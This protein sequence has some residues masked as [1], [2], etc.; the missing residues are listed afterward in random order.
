MLA[1]LARYWKGIIAGAGAVAIVVQAAITDGKITDDEKWAI[2][3][4]IV[5]ALSVVAKGNKTTID[6]VNAA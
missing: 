5:T 2:G 4:A 6:D 1:K 3:I